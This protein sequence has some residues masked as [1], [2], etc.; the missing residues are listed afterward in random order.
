[1]TQ[2]KSINTGST[3][4]RVRFGSITQTLGKISALIAPRR[5]WILLDEWSSVPPDLQP[6]LADMIR[7]CIL[8]VR[9]IVVK[10]AAIEYRSNFSIHGSQGEYT[11]IEI[12]ADMAADLNLDD[13]MVFDNDTT[14][15]TEF[16]TK[17]FFNHIQSSISE[18]KIPIQLKSIEEFSRNAFTQKAVLDELV[19]AAEGV[20]RDAINIIALAAQKANNTQISI[21]NTRQAA[22][23]W[24]QRDKESAVSSNPESI[25]LLRW[26][27]DEVIAHRKARAFLAVSGLRDKLVD[28]L[29]DARVLHILKKNISSQDNPGGR[30][31]ALKIDYGCYVDLLTTAKEPVGL[32][33]AGELET[34]PIEQYLDVPPDDYRAIRRAILDIS[35][36][37]QTSPV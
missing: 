15:S 20:P 26:I 35:Q 6:Y 11:G 30:Y 24:Y 31:D 14:R 37:Y 23:I 36:F 22:K 3:R 16:F 19:R 12:G 21:I 9:G 2:L 25:R 32:F 10:I 27:A 8:P 34:A 7:R 33:P 4:H 17:L 5:I 29:F 18:N 1:A 28:S 13:F